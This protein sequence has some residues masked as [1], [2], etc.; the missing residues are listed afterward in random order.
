MPKYKAVVR[1]TSGEDKEI[2][3]EG[4][5]ALTVGRLVRAKGLTLIDLEEVEFFD[6]NTT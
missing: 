3:V 1:N 6:A 5:D 2:F 4:I